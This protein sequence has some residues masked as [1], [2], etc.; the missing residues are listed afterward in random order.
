MAA[1]KKE[2]KKEEEFAIESMRQF[3][4]VRKLF[5]ITSAKEQVV[6]FNKLN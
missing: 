4:R 1:S 5:S 6:N 3:A 2:N